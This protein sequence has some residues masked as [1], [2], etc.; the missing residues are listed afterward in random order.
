MFPN[1]DW[2]WQNG[3]GRLGFQEINV[4]SV[5]F[6]TAKDM[7]GAEWKMVENILGHS[8]K[9]LGMADARWMQDGT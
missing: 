2:M 6:E 5:M 3:L 4:L 8:R 1:P 7:Q 9:L